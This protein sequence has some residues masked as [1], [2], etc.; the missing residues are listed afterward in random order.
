M[1]KGKS[2][3]CFGCEVPLASTISSRSWSLLMSA[4]EFEEGSEV[5]MGALTRTDRGV[6]GCRIQL[7]LIIVLGLKRH[8]Q[9]RDGKRRR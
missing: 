8:R 3:L 1:K 9:P 7:W 5:G 2:R 4:V 6:W